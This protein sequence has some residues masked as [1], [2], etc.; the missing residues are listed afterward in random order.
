MD[1]A[2][3]EAVPTGARHPRQGKAFRSK[4]LVG[5]ESAGA[6]PLDATPNAAFIVSHPNA[7]PVTVTQ[8]TA[9][10]APSSSRDRA[11]LSLAAARIEVT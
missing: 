3:G 10:D 11:T 5:E 6:H 7:A 2:A 8:P 1:D 9:L 4:K